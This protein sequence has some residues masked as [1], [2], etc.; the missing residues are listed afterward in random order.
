MTLSRQDVIDR[1]LLLTGQPREDAVLSL[2][3]DVNNS[4]S[5]MY[6]PVQ[7]EWTTTI[8]D[9]PHTIMI[10]CAPDWFSLGNDDGFLR[11]P[12][13]PSTAQKLA[14]AHGMILP[15]RLLSKKIQEHAFRT[16][17]IQVV[18]AALPR[19]TP[20]MEATE[21]WVQSQDM[22][23]RAL[24]SYPRG[25][26]V[27]GFK[28]DVI[29]KPDLDGSHVAIFGAMWPDG[30]TV[31]PSSTIHHSKYSDYSHGIR[32][33]SRECFVDGVPMDIYTVFQD[34]KLC[35]LVSDEGPFL[36]RFPNAGDGAVA[37]SG[38]STEIGRGGGHGHHLGS[39]VFEISGEPLAGLT[40]DQWGD[41]I[42]E[43]N[44][45]LRREAPRACAAIAAEIERACAGQ[46]WFH[47]AVVADRPA[48]QSAH[49][50]V[51]V[52]PWI[53]AEWRAFILAKSPRWPITIQHGDPI[54]AQD[55]SR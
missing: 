39:G 26:L 18:P 15:S 48:P 17:P 35:A 51:R 54:V 34:P 11:C 41:Q 16:R 6:A 25:A 9:K 47:F 7:I 49:T 24:G 27:A 28:K 20:R 46:P 43:E 31:Q 55:R 33:I 44:A 29:V 12:T 53:P 32:F 37:V 50:V 1:L 19:P 2:A 5:W 52:A 10:K 42:L 8:D 45:R 40:L 21:A 4:P 23:Q 38:A 3:S 30:G 22:C 36:P 14:D 13:W